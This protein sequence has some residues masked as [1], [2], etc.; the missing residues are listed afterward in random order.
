MKDAKQVVNE[1]Y[2]NQKNKDFNKSISLLSKSTIEMY[3]EDDIIGEFSR[4][5]DAM[6]NLKS[7][8]FVGFEIKTNNGKEY[9]KLNYKAEYENGNCT[10]TFELIKEDEVYKINYWKWTKD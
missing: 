10:E 7:S 8:K 5:I 4:V 6:G 2:N 9:V 1:F 3:S